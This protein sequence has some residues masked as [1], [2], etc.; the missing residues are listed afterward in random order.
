MNK[1]NHVYTIF[2]RMY[3]SDEVKH[4][5]VLAT[6][7]ADAYDKAVFKI[8]P[9]KEEYCPYSAWVDSVTYDN[10]NVRYFN[11]FEGMPY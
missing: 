8:I 11:T 5:D 6:S 10:G 9:E 7:K 3:S 2:Y 1:V 4:I